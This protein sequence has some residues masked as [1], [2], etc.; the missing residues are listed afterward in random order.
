MKRIIN[1][2]CA[3][4]ALL[5][6][7]WSCQ[8][9]QK[10]VLP[11]ADLRYRLSR[12]VFEFPAAGAEEFTITVVSSEPWTIT[13]EHPDWCMISDEEGEA[14]DPATVRVGKAEPTVVHVQYYDNTSL[15]AR[16]DVIVIESNGFVAKRIKVTQAGNAYLRVPADQ[17]K[18]KI[19]MEAATVTIDVDTNQPWTASIT[20]EADWAAI[21]AGT[22]GNGPGTITVTAEENAGEMR[23]AEITV[24]DR[25]NDPGVK[26]T[27]TQDGVQLEPDKEELRVNWD[28]AEYVLSV[29]SNTGWTAIRAEG[30]ETDDWYTI[31]NPDNT[32]D[33]DLHFTILSQ[34]TGTEI[35][36]S[37]IVLKTTGEGFPVTKTLW[38]RQANKMVPDHYVFDTAQISLWSATKNETWKNDAIYNGTGALFVSTTQL[39]RSEMP[40]P[41]TY[42]YHWSSIGENARVRMWYAYSGSQEIKFNLYKG[43]TEVSTNSAGGGY[44]GTNITFDPTLPHDMG[45]KLEPIEDGYCKVTFILDENE[46]CS[47]Y[48][49]EKIMSNCKWGQ[50]VGLY[51]GVDTN[52][53]VVEGGDSAVCEWYEYTK[54]FTWDEE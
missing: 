37:Y 39:Y 5:T 25:N 31:D 43:K 47:F 27:I 19:G 7:L 6:G 21:T 4:A 30:Y 45:I 24:F 49:T 17:L 44:Y 1:I 36:D 54:T 13:S 42:T 23:Y 16:N 38:L 2:L 48:S 22:S 18:P 3:A 14:S 11:T 53:Q 52:D 33:A 12:N 35:R 51:I 34:N 15:E 46:F 9:E 20:N 41:G 26:I 32:G 28:G 10:Q 40:A 8:Q 50:P 29:K